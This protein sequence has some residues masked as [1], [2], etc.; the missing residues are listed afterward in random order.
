MNKAGGKSKMFIT[1]ANAA[2]KIRGC[3][4]PSPP[5]LKPHSH[6]VRVLYDYGFRIRKSNHDDTVQDTRTGIIQ[7]VLYICTT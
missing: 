7:Y 3:S 1:R 2:I 4:A 6:G 5:L